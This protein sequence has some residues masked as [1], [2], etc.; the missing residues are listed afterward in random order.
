MR[1]NNT[2]DMRY[3]FGNCI[4]YEIIDVSS[5]VTRNV[6]DM[7]G[8]FYVNYQWNTTTIRSNVKEIRGLQNFN[9]SKVRNM[10][11][12]FHGQIKIKTLDL[13]SFDT[14][15][16]V[17]MSHMFGNCF[18]LVNLNLSSFNTKNVQSMAAMFQHTTA[19][20][21]ID[22]S[23]FDT[24][25]VVYMNHMFGCGGNN[26]L[27]QLKEI[28]GLDKF[29]TSKVTAMQYMFVHQTSIRT[30]DLS[31][32]DT[33]N[34]GSMNGMFY[35]T[36]ITTIYASNKFDVTNLANSDYMFKKEMSYAS[37]ISSAYVLTGGAGTTYDPN[38]TN[39]EYARIDDPANG[40]PGY[41]TL[42]SN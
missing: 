33:R 18:A 14:G 3:M 31:S 2:V 28:R 12:M 22:L 37:G 11:V 34:V 41:F 39:K 9:T 13:S 32:F 25:N 10:N 29:N 24:S 36:N 26:E 1:T 19:I 17:D 30:V 16:V 27:C 6:T 21:V 40:K 42:K 20:E 15:Q 5:F 35:G 23:S 8:M 7:R 4:N 38:H